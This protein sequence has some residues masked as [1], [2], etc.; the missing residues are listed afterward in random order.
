MPTLVITGSA[1][2]H[3][4]SLA[5]KAFSNPDKSLNSTTRVVTDGS[6]GGPMFPD[7]ALQFRLDRGLGMSH[8]QYRGSASRKQDLLA[9]GNLPR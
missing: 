8:R 3:A 1:S 9:A 4:T 7:A 6:T 5:D 2:T